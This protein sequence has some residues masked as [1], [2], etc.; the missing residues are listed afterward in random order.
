[1]CTSTFR[2]G[3]RPKQASDQMYRLLHAY[4]DL[5]LFFALPLSS[6]GYSH[7]A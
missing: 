3:G 1:M 7:V 5:A 2:F 6:Y 4:G